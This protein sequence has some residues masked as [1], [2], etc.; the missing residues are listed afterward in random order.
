MGVKKRYRQKKKVLWIAHRQML[1]DQA[2]DSFSNQ[3]YLT[4][5][6]HISSFNFRIVSGRGKTR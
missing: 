1:L 2:L 3:A 5:L 6:P 4:N